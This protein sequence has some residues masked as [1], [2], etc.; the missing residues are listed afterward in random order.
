MKL[1]KIGLI[2]LAS[3]LA[4]ST[5][6]A[7]MTPSFDTLTSNATVSKALVEFKQGL[8]DFDKKLQA[9]K[10]NVQ[11]VTLLLNAMQARQNQLMIAQNQK[12]IQLLEKQN[13]KADKS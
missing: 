11:Q 7:E 1:V 12:I 8:T 5:S 4:V 13:A 3:S 9:K 6:Y 10:L 2:T